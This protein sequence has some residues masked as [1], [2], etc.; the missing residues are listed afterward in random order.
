MPMTPDD[1]VEIHAIERLKYRYLRGLD[2]KCWDDVAACFT[3]D[4][5]AAYSGGK[6]TYEGR[7][8]ILEFLR[9]AMGAETFHSSHRCHH[10]EIDLTGPTT[11]VGTWA[12][13]DVVVETA[14]DITIR[15]AA[16][17][18]DE[19]QKLG[20]EWRLRRTGYRRTYEEILPRGSIDGLRLTASWWATG[21]V[22]DLDAG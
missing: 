2:Q 4:A 5:V 21:G 14:W 10:P 12:M 18:E 8:A 1:L 19:Y 13:D 15:G 11:A 7:D 16:F 20:G 3:A 22:S 9:G 17:Y 6:Y